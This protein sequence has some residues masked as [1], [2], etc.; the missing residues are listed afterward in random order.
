MDDIDDAEINTVLFP[1]PDAQLRYLNRLESRYAAEFMASK[2]GT[3]EVA[4]RRLEAVEAAIRDFDPAAHAERVRS[5]N[6][7]T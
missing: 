1:T 4:R 7:G 3:F 6:L 2:P 5:R